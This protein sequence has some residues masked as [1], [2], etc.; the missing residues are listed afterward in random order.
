MKFSDDK[1]IRKD[2]IKQ[3]AE[4]TGLSHKRI[5]ALDV[6]G[7]EII[8]LEPGVVRT[9][10]SPPVHVLLHT[11]PGLTQQEFKDECDMNLI[12]KKYGVYAAANPPAAIY[13]DVSMGYDYVEAFNAVEE[14]KAAFA[15]LPAEARR[16]LG[17]DPIKLMTLSQTP[18]GIKELVKMGFGDPKPTP[19]IAPIKAPE[20]QPGAVDP[21]K[22]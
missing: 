4:H 2:E 14:A 22:K 16:A 1:E 13:R 9:P 11:G 15:E 19:E 17:E 21:A 8:G 10:M 7:Q 6:Y 5:E 18:E 12:L 3:F 20:A